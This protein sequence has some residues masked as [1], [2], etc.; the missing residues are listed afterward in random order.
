MT[1]MDGMLRE[2]ADEPRESQVLKV[3]L[4]ASRQPSSPSFSCTSRAS[5]FFFIADSLPRAPRSRRSSPSRLYSVARVDVFHQPFGRGLGSHTGGMSNTVGRCPR[6]LIR[7]Y[8]QLMIAFHVGSSQLYESCTS[9][10][11]TNLVLIKDAINSTINS[12][13]ATLSP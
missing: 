9:M 11:W 3:W 10:S 7:P 4:Y 12:I 2:A 5:A 8:K 1:T 13:G 6:H